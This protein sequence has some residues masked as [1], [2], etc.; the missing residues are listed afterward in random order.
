MENKYPEKGTQ[1]IRLT[2]KGGKNIFIKKRKGNTGTDKSK[3]KQNESENGKEAEAR[4]KQLQ[5]KEIRKSLGITVS[6]GRCQ[7]SC[8]WM[9]VKVIRREGKSP[10]R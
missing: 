7:Q 9:E 2:E 6:N 4:R 5:E 8:W 1:R 3:G 10:E